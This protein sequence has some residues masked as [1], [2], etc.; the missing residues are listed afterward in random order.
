MTLSTSQ[1]LVGLAF[2]IVTIGGAGLAAL[3][4]V[5]K[6]CPRLTGST[7]ALAWGIL[8]TAGL[9][10]EHLVPGALGLLSRESAAIVALLLVGAAWR[11]PAA[12]DVEPIGFPGPDVPAGAPLS[13]LARYGLAAGTA[14]LGV[15]AV[16]HRNEAPSG[17][18]AASAYLPTVA[19]WIQEG[20]IWGFGDWVPGFFFGASPGNGSTIVLAGMLP[21]SNDFVA[22]FAIFPFLP[23]LVLAVYCL[24]CELRAPRSVAVL[25]GLCLAALPVVVGP[26]VR[27]ALLDPVLYAAFAAGIAFL[28]RHHRTN[29]T[30]DLVLGG[31]AL[32]IAF[33][34]KLY[35]FTAVP[36]VV[37]LWLVARFVASGPPRVVLR[38]LAAVVGLTTAFGGLWV[39]RNTIETG[40]PIYPVSLPAVGFD[41]PPDPYR[42]LL[43]SS[44]LDYVDHPSVWRD[45]LLHQ[46]RIAAGLPLVLFGAMTLAAVVIVL[47]RHVDRGVGLVGLAAVGAL[48][49]SYMATPYSAVGLPGDP[50]IAAA[51]VRYGVPALVAAAGLA[52]WVTTRLTAR[53]LILV[54]LAALVA[55]ADALQVGATLSRCQTVLAFAIAVPV[56]V[57][58]PLVARAFARARRIPMTVRASAVAL[59]LLVGVTVGI[60]YEDHYNTGRFVGFDAALDWIQVNATADDDVAVAGAWSDQ[61]VAPIYPTFGSELQHHVSYV[62]PRTNG[63][64][65]T[66][67]SQ[68]PYTRALHRSGARI[69]LLGRAEPYVADPASVASSAQIEAWSLAAGYQPV[70]QSRRFTV[71]VRDPQ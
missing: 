18:D 52:G 55:F 1:Y 27:D 43:G 45:P 22:R 35:G 46:F 5:Q 8:A 68:A 60:R 3:L 48:G 13:W 58:W 9:L 33:G 39:L 19:R 70:A 26:V 49:L 32:G 59:V 29:D 12:P 24:A 66:Y 67:T 4:V 42:K 2:F 37:A 17:F 62:G 28:V 36:I 31:I 21:W 57:G 25:V 50:F 54:E 15:A 20:S 7:R 14:W 71:L 51:N 34:T 61:G 69:L 64:L 11:V 10:V 23:L 41:A 63:L 47:R 6:R 30:P 44:L 40:N 38:Q 53:S 65:A 56:V 16:V